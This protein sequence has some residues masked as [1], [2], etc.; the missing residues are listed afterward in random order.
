MKIGGLV[1]W[2]GYFWRTIHHYSFVCRCFL[3]IN[4]LQYDFQ[5]FCVGNIQ[6]DSVF[7]IAY[8]FCF[9]LREL[10]AHKPSGFFMSFLAILFQFF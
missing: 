3:Y 7:D 2:C 4:M 5:C 1:D 8:L 6:G 10:I 9:I